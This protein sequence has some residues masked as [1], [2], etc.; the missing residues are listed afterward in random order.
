MD[1]EKIEFTPQLKIGIALIDG[2]HKEYLRRLNIFMEKCQEGVDLEDVCDA[3]DFLQVYAAEHFDSEEYLMRECEYPSYEEQ[4]TFHD[5][6]IEELDKLSEA[7]KT[8]GG[9]CEEN[10]LKLRNLT[11]DWFV[12]HITE[13]DSKIAEFIHAK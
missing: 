4:K 11:Y 7:I 1:Y 10:L 5:Y 2:Q 12:N 6:F 13:Q 3:L 8:E 9:F